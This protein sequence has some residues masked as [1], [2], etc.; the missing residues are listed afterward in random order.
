MN[1]YDITLSDAWRER[2]EARFNAYLGRRSFGCWLW[3]GPLNDKG[4]GI[5]YFGRGR[6][7]AHRLSWAI[8]HGRVPN[9]R[10]VLHRCDNPKCCNPEHLFLGTPKDNVDDMDAKGRRNP[11][12]GT[13]HHGATLNPEQ[14][15]DIRSDPRSNADIGR[16]YGVTRSAIWKVKNGMWWTRV[17]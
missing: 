16:A 7:L 3:T 17:Q 12:H 10:F 11:V 13:A 15:R 4:Y 14:V 2:H 5:F 9:D 1:P 8:V 6:V